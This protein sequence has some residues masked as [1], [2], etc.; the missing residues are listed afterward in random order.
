MKNFAKP[1]TLAAA[2]LLLA[3]PRAFSIEKS[4]LGSGRPS[5]AK[6]FKAPAKISARDAAARVK[7]FKALS[8]QPAAGARQPAAPAAANPE[9]SR[10]LSPSAES[11]LQAWTPPQ[12]RMA[13][14]EGP[15]DSLDRNR[16]DGE[17]TWDGA[18]EKKEDDEKELPPVSSDREGKGV[19][20]PKSEHSIVRRDPNPNAAPAGKRASV[21]TPAGTEKPAKLRRKVSSWLDAALLAAVWSGHHGL[22]VNLGA[23]CLISA[24]HSLGHVASLISE[25]N[26]QGPRWPITTAFLALIVVGEAQRYWAADLLNH[27]LL[28]TCRVLRDRVLLP[29]KNLMHGLT[30]GATAMVPA[31]LISIPALVAADGGTLLVIPARR[32]IHRMDQLSLLIKVP[33][34]L[35]GILL[36][37]AAAVPLMLLTLALAVKAL[38]AGMGAGLGAG[39]VAGYRRGPIEGFILAVKAALADANEELDKV[40]KR[41]EEQEKSLN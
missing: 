30:A 11:L 28:P 25:D 14:E 19:Y 13:A 21:R 27:V 23:W 17:K 7:A 26:E 33:A 38:A 39:L 29:A 8:L 20:L 15:P 4:L 12:F 31:G 32:L 24:R 41:Y 34:Y 22:A 3:S 37:A 36:A 9:A 2:V 5:A 10:G 16:Q 1:L 40:M 35:A 18:G 6:E